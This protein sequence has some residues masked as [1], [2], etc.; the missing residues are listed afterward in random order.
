MSNLSLALN[1]Q[2]RQCPLHMALHTLKDRVS[3]STLS[4]LPGSPLHAELCIWTQ[5]KKPLLHTYMPILAAYAASH[6]QVL[7][8]ILDQQ[9]GQNQTS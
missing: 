4:A 3:T 8:E 6:E 2:C 7:V 1:M 5:P 9:A